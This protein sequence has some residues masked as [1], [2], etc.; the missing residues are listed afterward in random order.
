MFE[1]WLMLVNMIHS[2]HFSMWSRIC[3]AIV[4]GC[5]YISQLVA[6]LDNNVSQLGCGRKHIL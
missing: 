6:I 4:Y 2:F 3:F 5:E 1:W